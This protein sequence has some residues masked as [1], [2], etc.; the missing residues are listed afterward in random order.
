[1]AVNHIR[2]ESDHRQSG[3]GCV[4]EKRE[5]LQVIQPVPVGLGSA[6]VS[7][8][9]NEIELNPL[10]L[11]LQD[12][13]ITALSHIIHVEMGHVIHLVTPLLLDAQILGNHNPDI[14]VC[15]IKALGQGPYYVCQSSCLDEWYCF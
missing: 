9:V 6:E 5:L 8:I 11:V 3:E 10:I 2:L 12:P 4:A 1:M 14:I 7:F 15:L 13:H